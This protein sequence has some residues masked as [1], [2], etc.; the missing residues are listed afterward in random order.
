MAK[1]TVYYWFSDYK[2][3]CHDMNQLAKECA[4]RGLELLPAD[5]TQSNFSSGPIR[6]LFLHRLNDLVDNFDKKSSFETLSNCENWL[7]MNPKIEVVDPFCQTNKLLDRIEMAKAIECAC[8]TLLDQS[9]FFI[10]KFCQLSDAGHHHI[11]E[12]MDHFKL[13]FPII[14]KPMRANNHNITIVN[15]PQGLENLSNNLLFPCFAQQFIDHNQLLFKLYIL[16]DRIFC[17]QRPSLPNASVLVKMGPI[18]QFNTCILSEWSN[19]EKSTEQ[20][21]RFDENL[22]LMATALR[23]TLGIDVFGVDVIVDSKTGRL[24]CIDVNH[25]PRFKGVPDFSSEVAIYLS[26]RCQGQIASECCQLIDLTKGLGI[27]GGGG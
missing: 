17:F 18:F 22:R 15:S 7:R 10:P 2:A 1:F 24:A 23:N 13:N 25:F 19:I 8:S 14:I 21:K 26:K 4:A 16:G 11:L 6:L 5:F 9:V 12:Q 27:D 3:N 20:N